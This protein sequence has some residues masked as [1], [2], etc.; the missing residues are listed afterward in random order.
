MKTFTTEVLI[1]KL[2]DSDF[3]ELYGQLIQ[4]ALIF[5]YDYTFKIDMPAGC[6]IFEFLGESLDIFNLLMNPK[7]LPNLAGIL[8]IFAKLQERLQKVSMS[9]ENSR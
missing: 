8:E 9:G 2:A 4:E 3:F 1:D 5:A 7:F 6:K